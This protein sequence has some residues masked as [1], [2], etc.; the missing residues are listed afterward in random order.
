MSKFT[1]SRRNWLMASVATSTALVLAASGG[2]MAQD[3][4]EDDVEVITISG[5]RSAIES[6]IAVKREETSIVEAISAEDI[7]KLPDNSIAEALARL[8]GLTAQR[9]RGRAQ[10]I[11]VRGLGPEFST[12]LLNGREQ[13]TAGDN[14]GVEFD[15]YPSELLNQVVVYKTPD[16]SLVAQGLAGTADLRTVRPLDADPVQSLSARYEWNEYG[17]LN[18]G[19]EDSGYRVTGF[20]IDQFAN[21][22]VGLALGFALQSSP[23]QSERWDAWGYP[24]VGGD[25]VLGGAKPYVESRELERTAFVGT[26]EFEPNAQ[27]HTTIDAFYSRFEDVGI[28]RGI[29]FPLQWSNA[30]LDPGYTVE[31][32]LITAGS[33]SNVRGV[34]RNDTRFREADVFSLG[35]NHQWSLNDHWTLEGDLAYSSVDRDDTD[36]ETYAGT[37]SGNSTGAA[38]VLGFSLAD[39]G[40]FI[41]SSQ[42]DYAD[43][44]LMLLTDPQGWGQAGFI[45]QPQTEDELTTFRLS[46]QRDFN[47]GW[48]SSVEGGL[49]YSDREKNKD[50]IESFVDLANGGASNTTAIPSNLLLQPTALTFLGIPGVVSYDPIA[51]LNSGV[52]SLRALRNGDVSSKAWTVEEQVTTAYIQANIDSSW[53]STPVRGNFGL[54][55]VNTEQSSTGPINVGGT[56]FGTYTAVTITP[57]SCRA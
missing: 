15:Q 54:Q 18:A 57:R 33:F 51:M 23:T 9:L 46:A 29:E 50:S 55:V 56:E 6:A 20:M 4:A 41:F 45:K 48:I 35:I 21:D 28:L 17:A 38:D 42:L 13:V 47:S 3:E 1:H 11:S 19:S 10:V 43:P 31:N 49:Y 44:S 36:L 26:L 27:H 25:L 5:F 39:G 30:S 7:G 8:P 32:G 16:A 53:G 52:Y 22:T 34:V 37:G 40:N 12:A 24:D 14:R 2:A